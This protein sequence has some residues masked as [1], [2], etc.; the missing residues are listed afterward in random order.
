MAER[1][2][3]TRMNLISTR[4]RTAMAR[5]GYGILK[6]KREV[7]VLEFLKLLKSAGKDRDYMYEVL[8]RAYKT[9]G[10]A[11][12]YVGN[13]ELEE[14]SNHIREIEP[15]SL[16]VRNIMGVKVPEVQKGEKHSEA[17]LG[18][19][20]TSVAVD[21]I[22]ASFSEAVDAIIDAAQREQ[23]LKRIVLEVEKT[24]RRV[25]ALDYIVIPRFK[26]QAKY[27]STRL[28]EIDRDTFSA[29][30]HVKKRLAKAGS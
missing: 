25:N 1:I 19:L 23:G 28:E 22:N 8:Q 14:A 11:Y 26:S 9:L 17:L 24:K 3:P 7:L 20:S 13:F 27:I 18:M 4:R 2:T 12:A 16:S 10:I 15:I 6:K 29:L 5:K 21:D 30:K